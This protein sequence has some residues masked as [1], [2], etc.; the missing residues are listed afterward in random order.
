M[1]FALLVQVAS[2]HRPDP[3][4]GA[5]RRA[6]REDT[7]ASGTLRCR[8]LPAARPITCGVLSS[9][10]LSLCVWI[11]SP[12]KAEIVDS[13][14]P[15]ARDIPATSRSFTMPR[16]SSDSAAKPWRFDLPGAALLLGVRSSVPPGLLLAAQRGIARIGIEDDLELVH[17]LVEQRNLLNLRG[18]DRSRSPT[19]PR[20]TSSGPCGRPSTQPRHPSPD[21][22]TRTA[23]RSTALC[24][25]RSSGP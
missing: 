15:P 7:E 8:R 25:G 22:R 19:P 9:D 13:K 2:S 24:A 20:T 10:V 1:V 18:G 12:G 16:S 23:A 4:P 5:S 14:L 6:G 17:Q 11:F 21:R 3:G